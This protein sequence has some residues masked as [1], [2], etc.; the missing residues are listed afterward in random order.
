MINVLLHICILAM[1]DG[2]PQGWENGAFLQFRFVLKVFASAP[3]K[4]ITPK[5]K[6]HIRNHEILSFLLISI[7]HR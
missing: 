5:S 6:Q 7:K 4:M 3:S 2:V 1:R